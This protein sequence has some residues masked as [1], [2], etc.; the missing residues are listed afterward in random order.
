MASG[1]LLALARPPFDLGPLAL[2]AL[3]PL[4]VA[5][6][7]SRPRGRAGLAFLAGAVYYGI[8]VSWSWYFGA[9]AIVPFVFALAAYWALAGA[10]IGWLARWGFRSPWMIAAVWVLADAVVA[11]FPFQG[12]S[13]G[14]AGYALHDIPVARDVASVGGL[15]LITYA[16]VATNALLAD[17]VRPRVPARALLRAGAGLVLIA[18]V[19]GVIVVA[20]PEPKPAGIFRVALIQGNDKNREL[21]QAEEE[22][23]YLPRSH[24]A[25]AERVQDPVDLIVFPESSMDGDPRLD[26]FL[27]G[28]LSRL[29]I[30]HRAWVLANAV[31]DAPDGRALNLNVLY[32]PDG[33]VEGTYAKRHLVPYGERVPF[34]SFLEGKIGELNRIP[35]DFAPGKKPG[36][37][38]IAG[39]KV[40]TVI[41]FESAFGYQIR[42]LVR[43]GAEVIVVSTNNRSYRRS[44]N[45][46][47]HVAIGQIRAAE[48]GRPV[49][50]AAISGISALIDASGRE[51]AHTELFERT[52]LQGSV[53]ATR[54]TTLYVRFGDWVVWGSLLALAG[55]VVAHV[56]SRRRASV[57]SAGR[58]EDAPPVPVPAGDAA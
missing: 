19:T 30:E 12:F 37:F 28:P 5:W 11:R 36:L 6:R 15:A 35:R 39:F 1:L 18:L 24:F 48:T 7:D 16:I 55:C 49:V 32:G 57:D 10:V 20:R 31:T 43:D 41:C 54:G 29:A 40:A 45:S 8:L 2:V 53:E 14:E 38:D 56:V 34:R 25:L 3:V 26:P 47:Q 50:Q 9:I 44:A 51:H 58:P 13:W 27:S 4:F 52:V 22:D 42:P 33:N 23:R 17:A 46:A 21:T